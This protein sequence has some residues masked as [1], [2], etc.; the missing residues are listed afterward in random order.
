M[1]IK[2]SISCINKLY[3]IFIGKWDLA[4]NMNKINILKQIKKKYQSPYKNTMEV[5]ITLEEGLSMNKKML[6]NIT[7]GKFDHLYSLGE[8]I[9][10]G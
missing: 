8:L 1:K 9:G 10:R 6:I 2:K 3:N 5:I 7:T 4:M